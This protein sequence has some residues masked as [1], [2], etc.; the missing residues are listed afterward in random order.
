[1]KRG[2]G[3]G[4]SHAEG[5]GGHKKFLRGSLKFYL[6]CRGGGGRERFP[7]FKRVGGV[8]SFTLS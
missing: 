7:L 1:M 8:E 2:D 4:F 5:G 3:K 6:Y